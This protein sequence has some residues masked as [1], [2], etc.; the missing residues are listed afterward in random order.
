MGAYLQPGQVKCVKKQSN[1]KKQGHKSM[2][3]R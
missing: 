3:Y 2:K 1:G